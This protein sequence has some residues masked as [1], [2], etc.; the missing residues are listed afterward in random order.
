MYLCE[1]RARAF[2]VSVQFIVLHKFT[3]ETPFSIS[4]LKYC[5][6][7]YGMGLIINTDKCV[8][9][10]YMIDSLLSNLHSTYIISAQTKWYKLTKTQSDIHMERA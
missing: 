1:R 4:F 8:K 10:T 9:Q 2:I 7:G 5:E 6:Y 3:R